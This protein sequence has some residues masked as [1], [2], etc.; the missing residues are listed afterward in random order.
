[1]RNVFTLGLDESINNSAEL[2]TRELYDLVGQ[3]TGNL[4]FH[5]ALNRLIGFTPK[6]TPWHSSAEKINSMGD[7]GLIPCANNLG[8]HVD[9]KDLAQI[10]KDVKPNLAVIGIGAQGPANLD[11]PPEIPQG[12][13]DWLNQVVEHAVSEKPNIT[14]RGDFTLSVLENHG[15]SG[16]AVSLGCPSLLINKSR[17]L[18]ER[19]EERYKRPYRKIAIAA[20]QIHWASMSAL[21][22]SL[23][24]LMEDTQGSYI[25]QST[26]ESIALS[27]NDF[28][29][30]NQDY[31]TKLKNYLKLN[32]D[33]HDF[34]TWI[35][36]YMI[37]FYNIP[38]WM[39]Y[40]RKFDFIIG[41]RIHGV[42][43]AI[44]SGVPGLCIAH[45]SRIREI[46]EKCQIPFVM[47]SQV[48]DGITIND[49]K[50]ITKF[51]GKSF[52]KN[53]ETISGK[54]MEFFVNNK[55]PH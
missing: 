41:A 33:D 14:V 52:D 4:A 19:L 9:M 55:I 38:A 6:C 10:L 3:N 37:S 39:E 29:Y 1:M 15:F 32:L 34:E 35:R 28:D 8:S 44:Q 12:S 5:Y 50:N 36:K 46:C 42:M 51:D 23:V 20:G 7:L 30:T 16:K 22:A 48:K 26:D 27:R 43:L 45:D 54:Y 53:R 25:V 40:L 24:R 13:L 2:N 17:D 21:E 49:I 11:S 31:K 47:A 18:G